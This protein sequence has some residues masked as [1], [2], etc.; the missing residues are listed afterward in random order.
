MNELNGIKIFLSGGIDRVA[1]DGIQWREEIKRKCQDADLSIIFLDPTDKPDGL[2]CEV[3]LEKYAIKNHLNNGD[4]EAA[5]E[6][7]KNVRH[8][9]LRMVDRTD[10]YV[11]YIDLDSHLCGTY[12]ELFEAEKQQKPLFAIMKEPYTKKDFPAW[13]VSIFREEEVFN[14]IDE[15]VKYLCKINSGKIKQD[16]RWLR[17]NV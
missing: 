14:S 16:D 10:L 6:E 13:L 1:D 15:C 17:I 8:I 11:V 7:S 9:D 3:G 4:W 12:N 2:G 5:S